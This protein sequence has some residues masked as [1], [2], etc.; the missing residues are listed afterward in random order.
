MH[1][2]EKFKVGDRIRIVRKVEPGQ[3]GWG[4]HWNSDMDKLVGTG[5]I[6]TIEQVAS[7]HNPTFGFYFNSWWWSSDSLELAES[8]KLH[9]KSAFK[10][11]DEYAFKPGDLVKIT[12]NLEVESEIETKEKGKDG[13]SW[14]NTWVGEMNN[15]VGNN[16]LYSV[17]ES[18]CNG[19]TLRGIGHRWP[20]L[21]LTLIKEVY[22]S[23]TVV[24]PKGEEIMAVG[25]IK[26]GVTTIN[27]VDTDSIPDD[28]IIG[29]IT[30][31]E[32]QID[33]LNK[34]KNQPEKLKAKVIRIQA[35]IATLVALVDGRPAM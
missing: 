3:D 33:V 13:R 29:Y 6:F 19:V 1:D 15:F 21:A 8:V 9:D 23:P 2:P 32:G 4:C 20:S 22:R 12:R 27:G 25:K 17:K 30:E 18:Y 28:T 16:N 11:H 31:L 14:P 26:N 5:T 34:T 24:Q 35:D 10:L 7:K